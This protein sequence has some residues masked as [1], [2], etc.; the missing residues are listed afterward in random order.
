MPGNRDHSKRLLGF[1]RQMRVA[2]TD[3][4][5]RLWA[6]LR[7]RR[8][9]GYK[10]RRQHPIAGYILDF[11]CVGERLAVEADGGQHL[12]EEAVAD[13]ARRTRKLQDLG[14]RV[15]RFSDREVL[16]NPHGVA[17]AIYEALLS[18]ETG[19]SPRPSPGVPGEGDGARG[20]VRS[21]RGSG[22]T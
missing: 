20:W 9:D 7:S 10:F 12:D 16:K 5:R 17:D 2:K 6:V 1:A 19:P 13:D 8:L 4:E 21:M 11:F 3:A 14:I 22:A 18:K 15:L